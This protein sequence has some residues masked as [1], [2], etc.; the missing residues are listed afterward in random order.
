MARLPRRLRHDESV[1]LVDH[2]DEL[3]TRLIVS[4]L[5]VGVAFGFTYGFRKHI[6][7]WLERPLPNDTKLIT[8]GP[9]EAFNTSLTVALYGAI[10]IAIPVLVW[11]IWSF[12]AP[13][14]EDKS[15]TVVV[16]LVVVATFLLVAG[17]AFAYWVVLPNGLSFLLNFDSDLYD[18]TQVRARDYFSFAAAVIAG[19]GI[20]FELPIFILGLVRLGILSSRRLRKNRRIGV[21][22]ALIAVVLLPGVDFVSMALQALPILAL[23]EGSIW[24]SVYFERRWRDQGVIGEPL[25]GTDS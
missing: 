25:A 14:L 21:G 7:H 18:T 8:L 5:A 6:I 22:I 10:A 1:T 15:Q 13:V 12:F 17:M 3:R 19:L 11:Q 20:L 23:F 2:L 4:L 24:A 9:G 16:R